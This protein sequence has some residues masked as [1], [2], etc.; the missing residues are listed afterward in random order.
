MCMTVGK[1]GEFGRE[2]TFEAKWPPAA[3]GQTRDFHAGAHLFFEGDTRT[4]IFLVVSGWL[5][6]YRTL[7]DGQR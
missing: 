2:T 7:V 1:L 6:L 4:H 5:K 3:Q